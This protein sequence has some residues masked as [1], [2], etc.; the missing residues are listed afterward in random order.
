MFEAARHRGVRGGHWERVG[1][2]GGWRGGQ[3][4]E[5]REIFFPLQLCP[6]AARLAGTPPQP[7]LV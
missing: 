6:S 3:M 2:G 4:A 5:D 1:R 7:A